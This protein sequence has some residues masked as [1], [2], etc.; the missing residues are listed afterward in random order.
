MT[1]TVLVSMKAD[2]LRARILSGRYPP[3]QQLPGLIPLS[4]ELRISCAT[5]KKVLRLLHSEGLLTI[6]SGDGTYVSEDLKLPTPPVFSP[7][8]ATD[9]KRAR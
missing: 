7:A 3:G 6:R 4:V 2:E 1:A 8:W 9:R 5:L